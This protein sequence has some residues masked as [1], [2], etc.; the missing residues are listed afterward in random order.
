MI[1]IQGSRSPVLRE[2]SV[3]LTALISG[4]VLNMAN[5]T[6]AVSI[7]VSLS[8]FV[9]L[10]FLDR[11]LTKIPVLSFVPLA[12]GESF[13]PWEPNLHGVSWVVLLFTADRSQAPLY[14]LSADRP[15]RLD[16]RACA[17]QPSSQVS[18]CGPIRRALKFCGSIQ[19]PKGSDD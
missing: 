16:G 4:L 11:D 7:C 13:F 2:C 5:V 6:S 18:V 15:R 1:N 3:A 10:A 17:H 14:C 12:Q 9:F 19:Y 8:T